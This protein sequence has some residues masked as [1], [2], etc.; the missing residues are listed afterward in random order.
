[1]TKLHGGA[2]FCG[3]TLAV[4]SVVQPVPAYA[5]TAVT[6][7]PASAPA[8]PEAK[9][10]PT[11]SSSPTASASAKNSAAPKAS[12]SPTPAASTGPSAAPH[13]PPSAT[14]TPS[15]DATAGPTSTPAS[16]AEP[17]PTAS[18]EPTPSPTAS[19]TTLPADPVGPASTYIVGFRTDAGQ[20]AGAL[21]GRSARAVDGLDAVVAELT[22]D[23]ARTLADDPAV[24]YVQKDTRV[25][26]ADTQAYPPWGL[27]RIDQADLPLDHSYT[28]N[29]TGAG[30]TVYVVDT[31]ISAGNAE[32]AGRVADGASF[33]PDGLGTNDCHGHGTHVAGIVGGSTHGVAKQVTLVPV[34]VLGCDGTGDSSW[35]VYGL[36]WV[37]AQHH[38]GQPAVVNLSL[39]GP[40]NKAEND[41]V[42]RLT[43]EGVSVVVAA[44]NSSDDACHYSPGSA[45]SALTVAASARTDARWTESNYGSCVDLYAPGVAIES[46]SAFGATPVTMSGTSM[47]SPHVAGVAAMVLAA[48]RSWG[49]TKVAARVLD[50]TVADRISGN[51][52]GTPNRL[53]DIAPVVRSLDPAVGSTSGG[54]RITIT[55]RNFRGVQSVLVGGVPATKLDVVSASTIRVSTPSGTATGEAPVRVI[56]EL[57]D[58][59]ADVV[60][61]YRPGPSLEALSV[62]AGRTGGG[63]V[64][65]ITGT[66]L[67]SASAVR[68]GSR[69][70]RSFTV[71]SDTELQVVSPTHSSGAVYVR[72][73]TRSGTTAKA[74]TARFAYGHVPTVRK[75]SSRQGLSVGGARVRITGKYLRHVTSVDFGGVAGVSLRIA[76]STRLYV[77]VPAHAEGR[78]DVRLTNR[79][80]SSAARS[81]ARYTFRV[82]PA[83]AVAKV[84]PGSGWAVGGARVTITGKN[85]Y[86][87]TAV[88]FGDR[89]SEI[90]S[91]TSTRLVVIAPPNEAGQVPVQV[92]GA[93]GTSSVQGAAFTYL[94]TPAPEVTA[95]SPAA[96]STC[97]GTRVTITGRNFFVIRK[98][99]FGSLTGSDLVVLRS[100]KL[101]VTAPAQA[102]GAVDV[103][104]IA[105]PYLVSARSTAARYTYA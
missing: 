4:L 92:S 86:G 66:H 75:V 19:P 61:D 21:G 6:V 103:V 51:P 53:L 26:I 29:Q 49:A 64:V 5:E 28:A 87:I 85:F 9:P 7:A 57:S 52:S 18:V 93:Y 46:A 104:V 88:A 67:S 98:V 23:E 59:N 14:A 32:F 50:L 77:T 42:K 27:D 3:L 102:A 24:A 43:A 15:P 45:R 37:L 80:G 72:V 20:A 2:L 34:R 62:D 31:G 68:F 69:R 74:P 17:T 90:V 71:V 65:T 13:S 48:H 33:V 89:T 99:Y 97:G 40:S 11:A 101:Q 25:R 1:M 44:G 38:R 16:S 84:G 79:Y 70:A 91:K 54:Q 81:K 94:E 47:A 58:S 105:N 30:V 41:A 8:T 100:T 76:S 56:T 96:G 35:T 36:D 95:V 22:R 55:G 78:V 63:T 60:F 83:P 10:S 82:A 12:A 39:S 73:T